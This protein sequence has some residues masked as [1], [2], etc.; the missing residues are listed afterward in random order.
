MQDEALQLL[1]V[2]PLRA[3]GP[4]S[5][6]QQGRATDDTLGKSLP[7]VTSEICYKDGRSCEGSWRAGW[8]S[9]V[10]VVARGELVVVHQKIHRLRRNA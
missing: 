3:Q 6:Q 4:A 9:P 7:F 8:L 1:H 5:S 10:T 2:R